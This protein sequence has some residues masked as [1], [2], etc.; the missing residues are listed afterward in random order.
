MPAALADPYIGLELGYSNSE[1]QP[2]SP[3]SHD[4]HPLNA[5][6]QA[7][8]FINDYVGVEARYSTSVQR[9]SDL[10]LDEIIAGFAKFNLPVTPRI[11][12]YG[13]AGYSTLTLEKK[14]ASS[15]DE[16]G[17]SFGGGI[18]FA[19]DSNKAIALDVIQ[20]ADGDHAHIQT[21]NLGFQYRF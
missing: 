7:G 5:G 3:A 21:L 20:Y 1:Y 8:Y 16:S 12:L 15:V 13:L 6:V 17:F 14:G 18:H 11:A 4:G 19:L 10:Q 9:S 2:D